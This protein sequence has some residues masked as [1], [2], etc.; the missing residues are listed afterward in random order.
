M[1]SF[2]ASLLA[3]L[4]AR[5]PAHPLARPPACPPASPLSV[6]APTY[7]HHQ[8]YHLKPS[9]SFPVSQPPPSL[10]TSHI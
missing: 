10:I 8:H 3:H 6:T 7:T 5:L 9:S 4:P 1:R 2:S